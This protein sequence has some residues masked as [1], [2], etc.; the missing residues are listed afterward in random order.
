[1]FNGWKNPFCNRIGGSVVE[2]SPATRAARVRFPADANFE[3]LFIYL[4]VY[5][6]VDMEFGICCI[7][8]VI[9]MC[10]NAVTNS[11]NTI[12]TGNP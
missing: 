4:L 11:E 2:C 7:D 8:Q 3:Y 10:L 6:N 9:A 1:M 12:S 5:Y